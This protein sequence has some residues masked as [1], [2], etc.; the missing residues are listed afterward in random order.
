MKP[1]P[2]TSR[3]TP[4]LSELDPGEQDPKATSLRGQELKFREAALRE[5]DQPIIRQGNTRSAR[6]MRSHPAI[7]ARRVALGPPRR[8]KGPGPKVVDRAAVSPERTLSR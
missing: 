2:E 5:D 6:L 1:A 4:P 8:R 7:R 3:P